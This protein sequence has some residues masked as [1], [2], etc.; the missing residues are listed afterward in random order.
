[1]EQ[2][3]STRPYLLRAFYDWIV[4]NAMTP[5]LLVKADQSGVVVP[6]QYV[7]DGKIVLNISPAAIHGLRIEKDTVSFGGRFGGAA[8]SVSVPVTAVE[9]IY[10]RENGK[11]MV[12]PPEPRGPDAPSSPRHGKPTLTLVK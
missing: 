3:L 5:H 8:F 4:D 6:R 11:G 10:A 1:M 12:F 2:M 7:K 9:A